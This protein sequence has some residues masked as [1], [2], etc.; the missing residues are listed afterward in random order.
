MVLTLEVPIARCGY[1]EYAVVRDVFEMKVPG[2]S[3]DIMAGLEGN[4]KKL[5][6]AIAE[7][8][9]GGLMRGEDAEVEEEN[10]E[11]LK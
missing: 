1:Y 5:R 4:S 3:E 7:R 11:D 6:G 9:K 2:L 10:E 8:G